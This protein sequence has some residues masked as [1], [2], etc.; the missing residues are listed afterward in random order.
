MN[1]VVADGPLLDQILRLTFEI[2]NEGLEL[3]AYAQWNAAQRRTPWGRAHLQRF[4]LLD[5][6]G[7]LLATAKRYRYRVRLDVVE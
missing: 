2:W 7:R 3:R 4:A 1:V 6:G 5:N